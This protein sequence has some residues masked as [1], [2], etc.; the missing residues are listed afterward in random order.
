MQ[1][2][3]MRIKYGLLYCYDK[4]VKFPDLKLLFTKTT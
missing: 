3:I 4:T 2:T 1:I